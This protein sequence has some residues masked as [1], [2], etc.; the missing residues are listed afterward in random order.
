MDNEKF[1]DKL[2]RL[3]KL[4]GLSQKEVAQIS[5]I[6]QSSFASI[7]KGE[8]KSISIDVGIGIAKALNISFFELFNFE[9]AGNVNQDLIKEVEQ[10]KNEIERLKNQISI[11]QEQLEDKRNII[12]YRDKLDELIHKYIFD[13]KAQ[14]DPNF[15]KN[16]E[17]EF[18]AVDNE[19]K[20]RIK[21][22][23]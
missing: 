11:L 3:R 15:R 16:M 4:S 6:N 22:K 14:E 23:D 9:N 18:K 13:E 19:F 17:N 20:N 1:T 8:T 5:G 12:W 21:K 10:C 7:E 2:K